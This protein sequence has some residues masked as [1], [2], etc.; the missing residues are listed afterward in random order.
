MLETTKAN[1]GLRSGFLDGAV[2]KARVDTTTRD[3][4][5]GSSGA[6]CRR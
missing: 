6:A 5:A 4:V 3:T 2:N 1:L